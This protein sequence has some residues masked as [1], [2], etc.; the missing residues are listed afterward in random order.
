MENVRSLV[1][2]EDESKEDESINQWDYMPLTF[3][4]VQTFDIIHHIEDKFCNFRLLCITSSKCF[5]WNVKLSFSCL[6]KKEENN[7]P[8]DCIYHQFKGFMITLWI[9]SWAKCQK[10]LCFFTNPTVELLPFNVYNS[11]EYVKII[12]T[13]REREG[14]RER[15]RERENMSK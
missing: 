13:E 1:V 6:I 10:F 12:F 5:N 15:Q 2:C 3:L 9:Q 14:E 11:I 4:F 8:Q 7:S